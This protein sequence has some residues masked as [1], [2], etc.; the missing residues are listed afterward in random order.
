MKCPHCLN[1]YH[2]QTETHNLGAD[3]DGFWKSNW[4]KC[5]SCGKF[6]IYLN[7]YHNDRGG[8]IDGFLAYPKT[9]SRTPLSSDVPG[10]FAKD[11]K[12]ACSVIADSPKASAAL[13]RRCLQ[14]ILREKAKV[15]PQ[16]LSK[17]I[18]EVLLSKQLPSYLAEGIDAVRNIGNFAAH[19]MKSTNTGEVVDVEPGEA[20]WLLDLLEGLF[21]FYFISPAELQRKKGELNKKLA[22]AGK[23]P[24]K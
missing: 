22:D 4:Q 15:K 18:D 23:P 21:D 17:E 5:P 12:E 9:I 8:L 13:S 7:R 3:K 10:E 14:N 24:M 20:E 6:I 16:D 1:S 2:P 11:Y 19:P